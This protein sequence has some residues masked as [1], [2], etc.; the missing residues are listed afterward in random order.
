MGAWVGV[1]G[2]PS[3]IGRVLGRK[4]SMMMLWCRGCRQGGGRG[5]KQANNA[6][7]KQSRKR[8]AKR[9]NVCVVYAKC[10]MQDKGE[11]QCVG[12]TL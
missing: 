8:K 1:Q 3:K 12:S 11:L 4:A 9:L 5:I 6:G 2:E 7:D 10:G